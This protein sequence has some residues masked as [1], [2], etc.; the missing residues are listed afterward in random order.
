MTKEQ[1]TQEYERYKSQRINS[2][3][4]KHMEVLSDVCE[5]L[6]EQAAMKMPEVAESALSHLASTEWDNYLSEQESKNI[7]IRT[8]NQDGIRRL[9]ALEVSRKKSRI[10]THTR[11][12]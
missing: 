11:S 6:F 7:S 9:R 10:T 4:I 12:V 3:D 1:M 5:Y 2:K 8:V